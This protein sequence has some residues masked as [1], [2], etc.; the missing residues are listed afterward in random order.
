MSITIKENQKTF[1]LQ[2]AQVPALEV[3][4]ILGVL[5]AKYME[6]LNIET[7]LTFIRPEL[8]KI[9][10]QIATCPYLSFL[11]SITI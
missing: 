2:F 10:D 5:K 11:Y 8:D 7:S 9:T 1:I 3:N 6:V 4:I